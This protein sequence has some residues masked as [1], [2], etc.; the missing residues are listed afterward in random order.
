M[1]LSLAGP[2]CIQWPIEASKLEQKISV[3]FAFKISRDRK[4]LF[5]SVKVR[6]FHV[7]PNSKQKQ[8]RKPI[9]KQEERKEWDFRK[10]G[11]PVHIWEIKQSPRTSNKSANERNRLI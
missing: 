2:S 10:P 8:R 4:S 11:N 9:L 6:S 7:Y 3:L 1:Y 5:V